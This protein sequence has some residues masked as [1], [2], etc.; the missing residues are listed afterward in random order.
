MGGTNFPLLVAYPLFMDRAVGELTGA[1]RPSTSLTVGQPLPVPAGREATVSLPGGRSVGRAPADPALIATE[2]GFVTIASP[3]QPEIVVAVNAPSAESFLQP[4]TQLPVRAAARRSD[5]GGEALP[6]GA[7]PHAAAGP[8]GVAGP[9]GGGRD[10]APRAPP[11][12]GWRPVAM[13]RV[14]RLA[15]LGLVAAAV[16]GLT[17]RREAT[18]VATVFVLDSS[19]SLGADGRAAVLDWAREAIASR[20][21]GARWRLSASAATPGSNARSRSC[22]ISAKRTQ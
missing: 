3:G 2:P 20:P 22:P 1:A 6:A 11:R 16:V 5:T 15:T 8:C 18:Q 13:A 14:A 9:A 4:A 21:A 17:V 7:D 19:D 10:G 12:R